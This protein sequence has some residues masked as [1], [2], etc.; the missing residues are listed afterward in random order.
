MKKASEEIHE[1]NP[2][3]VGGYARFTP[4]A[5]QPSYPDAVVRLAATD[6]PTDALV[7]LLSDKSPK[8]R[9][10]ALELLFRKQDPQLLPVVYRLMEDSGITF[11]HIVLTVGEYAK[12]F[13]SAFGVEDDFEKFWTTHRDRAT[14]TAGCMRKCCGRIEGGCRQ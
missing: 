9:T 5:K 2:L 4:F 12:A 3:D 14:G 10:L 7:S 1:L 13:L 8:V 11:E 6:Y